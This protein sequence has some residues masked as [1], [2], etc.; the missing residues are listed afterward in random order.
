MTCA[1]APEPTLLRS[2]NDQLL[3]IESC[4]TSTAAQCEDALDRAIGPV[5]EDASK[6]RSGGPSC[7]MDEIAF[8]ISNLEE[9]LGRF[10]RVAIRLERLA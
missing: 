1:A 3:A 6:G 9:V 10:R 7:A 8:T 4:M 5:P 2:L